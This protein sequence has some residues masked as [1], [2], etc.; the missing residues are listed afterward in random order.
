MGKLNPTIYFD[1]FLQYYAKAARLQ[2]ANIA[3]PHG[4]DPHDA[5][6]HVDDPLMDY[7][8]IYDCVERRYAGFSNALQ[9]LWY[10]S[11]NPKAWQREAAYDDL[12]LTSEDWLW[13][14]LVHRV[15]GSGA[16]FAHDHGFR[17][18]VLPDIVWAGDRYAQQRK[19]LELIRDKD[20]P[21]FTSIG[22]QIPAFPKPRPP[23]KTGGERYFAEFALELVR[24]VHEF[25]WAGKQQTITDVVDWIGGWTKDHGLKNFKFVYTAWVM[26]IAEY[27]PKRVDPASH[28]YYGAN[29][30][31][32]FDLMF[33]SSGFRNRGL[34]DRAAMELICE[35][36]EDGSHPALPYS[37]ED[38]AC[39]YIRY[40]EC[41]VPAGYEHL[42]PWQVHN[43]SLVPDHPKHR[44]FYDV[45]R[46][47]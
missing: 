33:D 25:C 10:G 16:S 7:I 27:F 40:V 23:F 32:A 14:F 5:R 18:S 34:R 36:V 13:V 17:N 6:H 8:P 41:Y 38:V 11:A 21:C 3:S 45:Q 4:R 12:S 42:E 2:D 46:R 26:D 1:D 47:D 28:V 9:Q 35:R 39:D 15:T 29:C 44:S 22:N 43:R 20:R 19:L 24:D 30:E 37:L 31:E